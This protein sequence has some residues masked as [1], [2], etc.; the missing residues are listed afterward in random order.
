MGAFAMAV[1]LNAP[2]SWKSASA[3]DLAMLQKLQPNILKAHTREF[4]TLLFVRFDDAAAARTALRN[5]AKTLM[6]SALKHLQEVHGR[7]RS[8]RYLPL[9]ETNEC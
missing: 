3:A 7:A 1:T 8:S 9:N 4:L 6:K 2:F 5:I